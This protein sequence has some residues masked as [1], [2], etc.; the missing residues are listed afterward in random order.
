MSYGNF[1]SFV[2]IVPNLRQRWPKELAPYSDKVIAGVYSDF[3]MSVDA[4]NNDAKF[5]EWFE[6]F[7]QERELQ[8]QNE[9]R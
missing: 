4:G 3:Y 8:E 5:P 6:L 1:S 9:T 7:E 2:K